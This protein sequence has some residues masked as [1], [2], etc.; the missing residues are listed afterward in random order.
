MDK[1]IR[2]KA[3]HLPIQS[4]LHFTLACILLFPT[5]NYGQT[6][7]WERDLYLKARK[8]DGDF[9]YVS[10]QD[11]AKTLDANTYY[12]EKTRKAVLYVGEARVTIAAY[13][14]FVLIGNQVLQM[15]ISA[16]Y[17]DKDIQLPVKFFLP[18]LKRVFFQ[19]DLS[20][21][22]VYAARLPGINI[23]GVQVEEKANGT[24]VRVKT[25]EK[26]KS[27]SIS[28]RFSR[29]WLYLDILG[30]RLN[31]KNFATRNDSKIIKEIIPVQLQEMVQ[32]SFELRS[33]MSDK[34]IQLSQ[35]NDE[36]LL[37]IPSGEGLNPDIV[38]KLQHVQDRWR[39]DRI[40]IDPGHGGRDPGTHGPTGVKEK[41]VVLAISKKLKTIIEREMKDVEVLMTRER[42]EY[43]SLKERTQF[44]NRKEGKLFVCIHANWNRNSTVEGI[45][46]Y[47][48]GLARSD[49][50]L[51]IARREN[52]VIKYDEG[53]TDYSQLTDEKII[54]ATMAQN[55]YNKESQDL[56]SMVLDEVCSETGLR[57]RGVKQAGFYVMVG[58]SMPHVYVETGFMSN[59]KEEKLLN[60]PSFQEDIAKGI[61]ESIKK[62][63]LKYEEQFSSN[64]H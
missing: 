35:N 26:F 19:E 6:Q 36:I 61:F 3:F 2:Q 45:E 44:A 39:M 58:A 23:I 7:N 31:E 47:F 24:L 28:T 53:P 57:N 55:S 29:N 12:S 63:K 56:A 21:T 48:L 41:D 50:S 9:Y 38:K 40:V 33:N 17:K 11:V 42:D 30:G 37:S 13:N 52:A 20:D 43:L 54:L 62:F 14:P 25:I 27:S 59:K 32:L 46:T 60:K 10:V 64:G 15:P 49:E 22:E 5:S 34:N 18:I 1:T 51:E 16:I 8:L 4:L